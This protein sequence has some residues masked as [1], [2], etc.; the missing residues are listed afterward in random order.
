MAHI[1]ITV[2]KSVLVS[3]PLYSSSEDLFSQRV[4]DNFS[5]I[6]NKELPFP[7]RPALGMY[8]TVRMSSAADAN[9][10]PSVVGMAGPCSQAGALG[11]LGGT[12]LA[13]SAL[14]A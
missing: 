6:K 4:T 7:N 8:A 9:T 5:S 1:L 11:C 2:Y 13:W 10:M 12:L 3:S 14:P